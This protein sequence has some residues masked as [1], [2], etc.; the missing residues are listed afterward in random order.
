MVKKTLKL[1]EIKWKMQNVVDKAFLFSTQVKVKVGTGEE[2]LAL[3]E[4]KYQPNYLEAIIEEKD[5]LK[6][7]CK[8]NLKNDLTNG[9]KLKLSSL[10]KKFNSVD[11]GDV[12]RGFIGTLRYIQTDKSRVGFDTMTKTMDYEVYPINKNHEYSEHYYNHI[13]MVIGNK[14]D[15]YIGKEIIF[16]AKVNRLESNWNA[17]QGR[18][19]PTN[20]ALSPRQQIYDELRRQNPAFP[21]TMS[22]LER[23]FGIGY[24]K[25]T[26]YTNNDLQA[27]RQADIP[28]YIAEIVIELKKKGYGRTTNF[29]LDFSLIEEVKKIY[30]QDCNS[31]DKFITYKEREK[32]ERSKLREAQTEL[33]E[34]KNK[35]QLLSEK[36]KELENE[37][38]QMKLEK[39]R[40]RYESL[41]NNSRLDE[42]GRKKFDKLAQSIE[43]M[44]REEKESDPYAQESIELQKEILQS[45][46]E[47]KIVEDF[48]YLKEEI[49]RLEIKLNKFQTQ[50]LQI[51]PSYDKK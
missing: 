11:Q 45:K 20:I 31:S 16:D 35:N 39:T 27:Y 19:E 6:L 23:S 51:Q 5:W 29:L 7:V 41:L 28:K 44:I 46:L 13:D 2:P 22:E 9:G 32:A 24:D 10:G 34:L 49:V 40:A 18:Y 50:S 17:G 47:T 1:E 25:A 12:V 21:I 14:L 36:V 42:E 4:I 37:L 43:K 38:F 30:S 48:C 33:E 15:N 26:D 8:N 3:Q